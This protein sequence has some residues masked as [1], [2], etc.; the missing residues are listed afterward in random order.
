M[1]ECSIAISVYSARRSLF[2]AWIWIYHGDDYGIEFYAGWLTE[3]SLSVDNLF[4][5]IIIMSRSRCPR[6]YQQEA[7]MVGIILAL[8]FRGIFI[9]RRATAINNFSL[10]LLR[11]RRVP[12]LHGVDAWSD[13]HARGRA[14]EENR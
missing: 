3:Y 2:G 9:A 11:L 10:D 4:V 1:K 8:I 7:L 5:F 13:T 6:K 14:P 12:H